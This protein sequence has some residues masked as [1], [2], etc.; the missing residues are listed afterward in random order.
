M[1]NKHF[2]LNLAFSSS[3]LFTWCIVQIRTRVV[4]VA[5]LS[6]DVNLNMIYMSF[7]DLHA[8]LFSVTSGLGL[9]NTVF[10]W[11]KTPSLAIFLVKE[12]LQLVTTSED[13]Q[14]R[15]SLVVPGVSDS[16]CRRQECSCSEVSVEVQT[17]P[18]NQTGSGTLLGGCNLQPRET[19]QAHSPFRRRGCRRDAR[20]DEKEKMIAQPCNPQSW[21]K[22]CK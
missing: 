20:R 15:S 4:V 18:T 1:C 11:R 16:T 6:L 10:I 12:D 8:L 5:A 14:S 22:A 19:S 21:T 17:E 9:V 13:L 3:Y 7:R 2:I